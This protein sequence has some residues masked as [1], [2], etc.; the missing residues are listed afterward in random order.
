M[1]QQ[2]LFSVILLLSLI[3]RCKANFIWFQDVLFDLFFLCVNGR[4][5]LL[6]NFLDFFI[7][8][9]FDWF[10]CTILNFYHISDDFD[11]FYYLSVM[12]QHYTIDTPSG[13]FQ[14]FV[15]FVRIN[16]QLEKP[17]VKKRRFRLYVQ[18]V[19]LK[20][21]FATKHSIQKPEQYDILMDLIRKTAATSD[22][23][24]KIQLFTLEPQTCS[25]NIIANYFV[26]QTT[27]FVISAKF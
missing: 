2:K 1:T 4:L 18:L 11:H 21:L 15:K 7:K 3:I 14:F 5:F 24:R 22:T 27:Q 20:I 25:N 6:F 19:S 16:R 13:I 12:L 17:G 10:I 8:F 9:N 23:D 26:Y